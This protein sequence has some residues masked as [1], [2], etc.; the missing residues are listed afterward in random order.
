MADFSADNAIVTNC[1]PS[2]LSDFLTREEIDLLLQPFNE[3]EELPIISRD[4]KVKTEDVDSFI[5]AQRK[6]STKAATARDIK[7]V[8]RWLWENKREPKSLEYILPVWL[9]AYLADMFIS[10]RKSDGTD[11]E[12]ISLE[13]IKNSL[14]RYLKDKG[15][16]H[17]LRGRT[18]HKTQQAL[19][20]KK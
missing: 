19:K 10:I 12:P 17:S 3:G 16:A 6:Q 5:D 15:C 1:E 13:S 9:D 2:E 4:A 18:F 14:N 8:Q 20:A 11:Y 7:N